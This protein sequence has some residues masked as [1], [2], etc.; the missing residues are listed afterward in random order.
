MS[1]NKPDDDPFEEKA[2]AGGAGGFVPDIVRRAVLTGVGALFMTEEGIRN[3]VG[4]LKVP[5][6]ALSFLVSQA[7]KSR[8]EVT[9]VVSQEVR[10]FLES[11]TLRRE[12]WKV[13]TGVT[14]EVNAS[15]RL[16]PSGEPGFKARIKK[17]K[18]DPPEP[19]AEEPGAEPAPDDDE[20]A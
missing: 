17:R 6:D 18:Y 16:K 4:E 1:T 15:I 7:E 14:L 9:R 5:K 2:A 19:P 10:R 3:I 13:L 12:V 8:T 20:G 11:D